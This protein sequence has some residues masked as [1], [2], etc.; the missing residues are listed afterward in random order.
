MATLP[1]MD[2]T[3]NSVTYDNR[4]YRNADPNTDVSVLVNGRH[5]DPSR[6]FLKDG[7]VVRIEVDATNASG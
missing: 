4:T 2:V 1:G 7:D 5:V 6:Y 3:A